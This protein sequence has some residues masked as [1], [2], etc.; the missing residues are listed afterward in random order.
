[1]VTQSFIKATV[2]HYG[3]LFYQVVE[4]Y[5]DLGRTLSGSVL[6]SARTEHQCSSVLNSVIPRA[7]C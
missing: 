5:G 6:P 1:M 2:K 3:D 7:V 4:H